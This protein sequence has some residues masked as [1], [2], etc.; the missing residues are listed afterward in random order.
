MNT[1][2]QPMSR[3][4]VVLGMHRSGTSVLTRALAAAGVCLGDRLMPGLPDNPKGFFEDLDLTRINHDLLAELGCRWGTLQLPSWL[5]LPVD[6]QSARIDQAV[7]LMEKKF[8][9]A[10][11]WG[12]KDPR[13]TRLLPFWRAALTKAGVAPLFV[14]ANR[15]P[16]SVAASLRRR[17]RMPAAQALALWALHQLAGLEALLNDSALAV[18]YDDLIENPLLQFQRINRFLGTLPADDARISEFAE[19]FI[20]P[21]LRHARHEEYTPE[22]E[23]SDLLRICYRIYRHLR[24]WALLQQAPSGE[25]MAEAAKLLDEAR[26]YLAAQQDWMQALDALNAR[27]DALNARAAEA[28]QWR[29]KIWHERCHWENLYQAASA[30]SEKL[31]ARLRE[32]QSREYH[33]KIREY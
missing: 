23:V 14:V 27:A 24:D 12:F 5:T 29:E 25:L 7:A 4:V 17:D 33:A 22:H 13:V 32:M 16:L 15:H 18:D 11:L 8:A 30:E 6:R 9:H 3:A 19:R 21:E 1:S 28:E 2:K 20:D 26:A 31:R 10:P